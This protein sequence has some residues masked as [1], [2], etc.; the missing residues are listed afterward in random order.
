MK[1][2]EGVLNVLILLVDVP[3]VVNGGISVMSL[4]SLTVK[5]VDEVLV[6]VRV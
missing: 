1:A 3:V 4:V 5:D 6:W 2:V